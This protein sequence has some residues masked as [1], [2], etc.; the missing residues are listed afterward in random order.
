MYFAQNQLNGFVSCYG[1]VCAI[2]IDLLLEA[3]LLQPIVKCRN[4]GKWKFNVVNRYK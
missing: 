3:A 4:I 2:A 1:Q